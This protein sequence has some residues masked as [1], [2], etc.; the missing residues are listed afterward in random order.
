MPGLLETEVRDGFMQ[1]GTPKMLCGRHGGS[2]VKLSLWPFY[3]RIPGPTG[4]LWDNTDYN[5]NNNFNIYL[6]TLFPS[7]F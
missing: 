7:F 3:G 6:E 1:T 4:T 5:N 2:R